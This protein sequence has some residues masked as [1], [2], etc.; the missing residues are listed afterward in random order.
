MK[1]KKCAKMLP[2][3]K[4]LLFIIAPLLLLFNTTC[5][6]IPAG[7]DFD[8]PLDPD[9]LN[10]IGTPSVDRDGDGIGGYRDVDEIFLIFPEDDAVMFNDT[11][12]FIVYEFDPSLVNRYHIQV[13]TTKYYFENAIVHENDDI[14]SNVYTL[15]AGILWNYITYY[16]RARAYDGTR[17]SYNWSEIRS[18]ILVEPY[19]PPPDQT[20][21]DVSSTDPVHGT[22]DVAVDCTV[23]VRFTEVMDESSITNATFKVNDGYSD[24]AGSV[25]SS[26][27]AA[28]FIP[29]NDLSYSTL[30]TV[31]VTTGVKDSAGNALETDFVWSFTTKPPP[32]PITK[33][34]D[35]IVLAWD[36]PPPQFDYYG[37]P[38]S[39]DSYRV[40]YRNHGD[41][42]WI[43]LDEIIAGD[44]PEYTVYYTDFGN[45]TY[46]FAVN[47]IGENDL[48]SELHRS[49]DQDAYPEGGWYLIWEKSD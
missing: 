3:L 12:D 8:N 19:P 26:G 6:Q 10:Y 7:P 43:L 31:T 23:S 13:S 17:W 41:K 47:A 24:A 21:P 27:R 29:S 45:G 16:W 36:P 37:E 35:D 14:G 30:Y 25:T 32:I 20:P 18:F 34:S 44:E 39:I 48:E 15:P 38:V 40:Y 11:F 5:V 4:T 1:N 28:T 42:V 22:V 9:S 33:E 46:E 49:I 2:K